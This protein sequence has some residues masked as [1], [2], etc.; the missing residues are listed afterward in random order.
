MGTDESLSNGTR[1]VS[2][3][4]IPYWARSLP[5]FFSG[6]FKGQFNYFKPVNRQSLEIC[7]VARL[8]YQFKTVRRYV[9]PIPFNVSL[10]LKYFEVVQGQVL[11][12]HQRTCDPLAIA[13]FLVIFATDKRSRCD[14]VV[15]WAPVQG[16]VLEDLRGTRR[17][18]A[19]SD[20]CERRGTWL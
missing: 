6:N 1:P 10:H 9:C 3:A 15:T 8:Q 5:K 16:T 2:G 17:S 12:A 14:S 7:Y 4:G 13:G 18:S 20:P 11:L 19:C